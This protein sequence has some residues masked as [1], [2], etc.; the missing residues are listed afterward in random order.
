MNNCLR[1]AALV[2][3]AGSAAGALAGTEAAAGPGVAAAPAVAASGEARVRDRTH[4]DAL[5]QCETA[6]DHSIHEIRGKQVSDLQFGTDAR[7]AADG[8]RVDVKGTGHYRR[9]AGAAP[10]SFH[11]TCAYDEATGATSG[12]LFREADNSPPPALPVW[13]ADLSRISPEACEAAAAASMQSS[14]PRASGI[15][16]DGDSRKLE[17]G[18]DGRTAL[19]GTGRV[20]RAP[21]MQATTFRYRCE[22]ESSGRLA[23]AR[24]SD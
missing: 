3:A 11:Y 22:F 8:D 13:Q 12:V 2:L 16:F 17:P 7:S 24:A 21:G 5:A 10:V 1:F 19:A 20:V 6:V 9:T 23:S 18:G 15:V 4:A 14:H